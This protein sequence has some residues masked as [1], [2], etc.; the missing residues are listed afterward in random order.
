MKAMNLN[1]W[2]MRIQIERHKKMVYSN[3]SITQIIVYN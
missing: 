3:M 2:T 1:G